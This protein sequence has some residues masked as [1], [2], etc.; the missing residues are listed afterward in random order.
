MWVF[1]L[2]PDINSVLARPAMKLSSE[3]TSSRLSRQHICRVFCGNV[4]FIAVLAK[5][6]HITLTST[7]HLT[8]VLSHPS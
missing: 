5:S 7:P 8:L 4:K 2:A 3:E 6:H 1:Y